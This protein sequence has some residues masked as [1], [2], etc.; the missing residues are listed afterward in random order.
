MVA[1]SPASDGRHGTMQSPESRA[2][3]TPRISGVAVPETHSMRGH[4]ISDVSTGFWPRPSSESPRNV[5]SV[6]Q[7][8]VSQ[9]RKIKVR[10]FDDTDG[11][12]MSIAKMACR[13]MRLMALV[14]CLCKGCR[15]LGPS[16]NWS[17]RCRPFPSWLVQFHPTLSPALVSISASCP[18]VEAGWRSMHQE[19]AGRV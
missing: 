2:S 9:R 4:F 11:P 14:L 13:M 17:R 8:G 18:S 5:R 12:S 7:R 1:E 19:S 3:V 10:V 6:F 15:S 16:C